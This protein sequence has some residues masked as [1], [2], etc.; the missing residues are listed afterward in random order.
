MGEIVTING[1]IRVITLPRKDTVA[2]LYAETIEFESSQEIIITSHDKAA[3]E[4]LV[5]VAK[6]RKINVLDILGSMFAANIIGND[7]IKQGML[8]C[9]ASTNR[10]ES[11]KK[12]HA[13]IIGDPG[14]AKSALLRRSIELVPNSRY[15]SAENSSGKSLTAIVE[16]E[17]ESHILRTGP[18]PAAKGAIC[19]LNELGRMYPPDQKHLLSI[20]QEQSFTINKHGINARITSPTAIIASANPINGEWNDQDMINLDEIPAMKPLIDRFDL[21]FVARNVRNELTLRA[22]ASRKLDLCGRKLIHDYTQYLRKYIEYSKRFNPVLSKEAEH[23]LKEYY[24]SVALN[25]GSPRLL[26]SLITITRM[27]ARLKL[28]NIVEAEDAFEAQRLYNV[29]LQ[30]LQ[31]VVNVVTNPSDEAYNTCIDILQGSHYAMQFE[32]LIKIAC[33]KNTRV[34]HYVGEKYKLRENGKLRPIIERLRNHSQI[35]TVSERPVALKW[36]HEYNLANNKGS[37]TRAG[38]M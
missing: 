25:Y 27:I 38:C 35:I 34:K 15:E 30:Q 18:I 36:D 1:N 11:Q 33:D 37:S 20:M 8:L 16:K 4:K 13:L 14:L 12:I 7:I 22:Y 19:A 31:Q 2:Y 23:M 21:I 17:D 10:E 28:K 6:R 26:E 24:I 5:A 29:I 3:I 9:A 32:E